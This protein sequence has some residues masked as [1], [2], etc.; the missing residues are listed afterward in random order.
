LEKNVI[1][2]MTPKIQSTWKTED[3]LDGWCAIINKI[4]SEWSCGNK[5]AEEAGKRLT[6]MQPTLNWG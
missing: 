6:L 4:V 3:R 2:Q 5:Q 1:E